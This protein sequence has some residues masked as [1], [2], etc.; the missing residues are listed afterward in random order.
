MP[1]S[2]CMWW[3]TVVWES[4]KMLM[5]WSYWCA[6]CYDIMVEAFDS[7]SR[8]R[9]VFRGTAV[10]SPPPTGIG[11]PAF[12]GNQPLVTLWESEKMLIFWSYRC[13]YCCNVIYCN[14]YIL[15]N[16]NSWTLMLIVLLFTNG[17]MNCKLFGHRHGLCFVTMK[18]ICDEFCSW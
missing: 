5:F 10:A 18:N 4:E 2:W 15:F 9:P 1:Y 12:C 3:N 7:W 14:G 13:A 6:Y 11:D 16:I 8:V 17:D